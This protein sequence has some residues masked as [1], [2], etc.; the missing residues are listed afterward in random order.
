MRQGEKASDKKFVRNIDILGRISVPV[1]ARR[2][3]GIEGNDLLELDWDIETNKDEQKV[4]VIRLSR[5]K[6][7]R[8]CSRCG[9]EF[10][11][12]ELE[13]NRLRTICLECSG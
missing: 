9:K 6:S 7:S 8:F 4:V 10:T 2:L 1:Q 3:L 5:V 11:A 13:Q 12:E